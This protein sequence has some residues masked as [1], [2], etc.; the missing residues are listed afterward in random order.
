MISIILRLLSSVV[1]AIA[2]RAGGSGNYPRQVRQ[3]PC[4]LFTVLACIPFTGWAWDWRYFLSYLLS[5][6][7][8]TG[9]ITMYW[10]FVNPLFGKSKEDKYW[11]NWALAGFFMGLCLLP[12]MM[13]PVPVLPSILFRS[14]ALAFAWAIWSSLIGNVVWEECGRGALLVLTLFLL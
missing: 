12:M 8:M 9:F 2:Y 13:L 1:S 4:S 7:L 10:G 3:F 11:W 6:G 14:V 5:F